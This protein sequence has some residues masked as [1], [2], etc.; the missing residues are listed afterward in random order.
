MD[1]GLYKEHTMR[2]VTSLHITI[3][4][5]I[6]LLSGCQTLLQKDRMDSLRQTLRAY[7]TTLRWGQLEQASQF[8]ELEKAKEA[9]IPNNLN[10]IR[11]TH[12]EVMTPPVKMGEHRI[13]QIVSIHFVLKDR[14]IEK[15]LTDR[16][17]WEFDPEEKHWFRINPIPGFE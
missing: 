14:Q 2:S 4:L 3:I 17:I 13:S 5:T 1:S 12:Y 11:V 10:N 7:E 8:L 15:T 6:L 9:K 16:Q